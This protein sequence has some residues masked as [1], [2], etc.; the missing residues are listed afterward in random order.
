MP[1]YSRLVPVPGYSTINQGLS[2]AHQGTMLEIFGRPGALSNNCSPITNQSLKKLI[3]TDDVGPFRATGLTL[4]LSEMRNIFDLVRQ[5]NIELYRQMH[6]DGMVCCRKVRG[7]TSNFSNHSW[8][9]AVDIRFGE[10][11]DEVG[12]GLTQ[13]GLL[14]LYPFF[15]V[16]GWYW[17]AG[18]GSPNPKREDAMHFEASDQLIRRLYLDP[19][20]GPT[21]ARAKMTAAGVKAAEF[22]ID[23]NLKTVKSPLTAKKIEG[24]FDKRKKPGLKGIGAAVMA[25]SEKCTD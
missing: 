24:Y 21:T 2:P 23:T 9:N 14:A 13:S 18:F 8:G 6:T 5:Q 16:H 22:S 10:D 15:Y 11:S 20:E 17:G 12:D 19:L 1:D 25:A 4:L 3:S 7:S